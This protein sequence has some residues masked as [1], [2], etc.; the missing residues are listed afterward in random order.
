MET[1]KVKIPTTNEE[2]KIFNKEIRQL[3]KGCLKELEKDY[4]RFMNDEFFIRWDKK[5]VSCKFPICCEFC[6]YCGNK[7]WHCH[8]PESFKQHINISPADV[9]SKWYPNIGLMILLWDRICSGRET[10][11][12]FHLEELKTKLKEVRNSSQ[13]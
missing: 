3:E 10:G 13:T 5:K 7:F 8:N 4:R 11:V 12:G 9:C 1:A 6:K 2:L